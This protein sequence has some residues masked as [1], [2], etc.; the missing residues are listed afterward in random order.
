[1]AHH[2][3]EARRDRLAVSI[4]FASPFE[5][6]PHTDIGDAIAVD[7][8]LARIGLGARP[9]VDHRVADDHV[10]YL[11]ARRPGRSAPRTQ[12]PGNHRRVSY[13]ASQC[14]VSHFILPTVTHLV[15]LQ[16]RRRPKVSTG[17]TKM[18]RNTKASAR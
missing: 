18:P 1:M 13:Q 11:R 2:V 14:T 10:V 4:D 12:R 6:T 9:V 7:R 15:S 8:N 16:S 5:R 3:D 17:S